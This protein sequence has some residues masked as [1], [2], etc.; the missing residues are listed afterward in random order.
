[1]M[2]MKDNFV[3]DQ[4]TKVRLG[5]VSSRGGPNSCPDGLGHLFRELSKFK[6]KF[7][8]FWGGNS[9]QDSC[10]DGKAGVDDGE[11]QIVRRQCFLGA[12]YEADGQR[13][14]NIAEVTFHL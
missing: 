4:Y 5:Q 7:P 1:M 6:W 10:G 12:Y 13:R 8:C 9:S 11:T 2:G 3:F 14:R